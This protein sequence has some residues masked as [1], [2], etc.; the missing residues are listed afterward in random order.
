MLSKVFELLAN[1]YNLVGNLLLWT[2]PLAK[3]EAFKE[4][5][6]APAP[7]KLPA[8]KISV[9]GLYYNLVLIQGLPFAPE[10]E[11]HTHLATSTVAVSIPE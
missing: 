9:A 3:L 5:I 11:N 6:L 4:V 7:E 1:S 10:S 2:V 8:D